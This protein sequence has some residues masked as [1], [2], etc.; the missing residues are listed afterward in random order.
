[1]SDIAEIH[2]FLLCSTPQA[3]LETALDNLDVLLID[4]ANC[5]KKAASTALNLI[6]RYVDNFVL[7][8]KMSK[9]AREELRQSRSR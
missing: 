1:M 7:L 6:Y 4:H 3:W 9:L 2:R 8:N 5:E